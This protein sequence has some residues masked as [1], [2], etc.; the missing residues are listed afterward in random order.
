MN[1]A[2]KN[3]KGHRNIVL[4][5]Q[6]WILLSNNKVNSDNWFSLKWWHNYRER[7]LGS[8][9]SKLNHHEHN[10]KSIEWSKLKN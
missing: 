8:R 1:D 9:F 2:R 10:Q 7:G 5:I 6:E 4:L 3:R